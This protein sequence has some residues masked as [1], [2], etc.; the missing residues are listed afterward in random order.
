MQ[1]L[2][3]ETMKE[4]CLMAGLVAGSCLVNFLIYQGPYVQEM[5]LPGMG[6]PSS[7]NYKK[8]KIYHRHTHKAT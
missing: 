4:Y 7:T 2:K 8:N 3:A 1:E 6:P 5:V